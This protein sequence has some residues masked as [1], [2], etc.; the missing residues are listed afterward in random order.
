MGTT[1]ITPLPPMIPTIT[2]APLPMASMMTVSMR[3]NAMRDEIYGRGVLR[4]LFF[5]RRGWSAQDRIGDPGPEPVFG[6][7][8]L[9]TPGAGSAGRSP[10]NPFGYLI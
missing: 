10:W 5:R 6:L 9:C 1:T 7:N 2:P 3:E 8:G 4:D